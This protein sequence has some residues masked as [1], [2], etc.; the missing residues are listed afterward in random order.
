MSLPV[1]RSG[2]GSRDLSACVERLRDRSAGCDASDDDGPYREARYADG[3]EV[4]GET[5]S[6]S[7]SSFPKLC[8]ERLLA[9]RFR[10]SCRALKRLRLLPRRLSESSPVASSSGATTA[11]LLL[12]LRNRLVYPELPYLFSSGSTWAVVRDRRADDPLLPYL[13]LSSRSYW[14]R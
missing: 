6:S 9:R 7:S 10:R 2:D 11:V 4:V 1:L 13:G 3:E 12:L 5:G 8:D 14:L